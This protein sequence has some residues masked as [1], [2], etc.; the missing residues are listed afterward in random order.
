MFKDAPQDSKNKGRL[1]KGYATAFLGAYAYNALYSSLVGRDAAFDPI[2]ILEDLFRDLFGDD[3]EEPEEA[4]LNLADNVIEEVPFIGGLMGGG[5]VPISSAIPYEGDY[6]TF[7]TD[8]ANGELSA[9]EMLKPVYYLAMP[10]AGGQLKKTNE[11]LKM[12]DEDLPVAGSYTDSGN[13]RFPVEDDSIADWLQAALFGQYASKN[14]REYFDNGWAPLEEK[15]IDE[16]ASLDIPIADYRE[17]R[18]RL[19]KLNTL[20]EKLAYIH[21]LDL[22]I[23]K[24]NILANNLTDRKTPIDMEGWGKL[25]EFDYAVKYPEKAQFLVA[26]G[27]S[28]EEYKKLDDDTKDAY[29]WAYLNPEKHAVSK[30]VSN[31]IV[32][33]RKYTQELSEIKADKDSTGKTVSG[34][35]KKKVVQYINGLDAEYG[36]KLVLYKMEY[37]SDDT[38][39]GKII[40]Y[41]SGIEG[42]TFE[43]KAT[44]LKE[45][46]FTVTSDGKVTWN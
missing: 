18:K 24:K 28:V 37:P 26:N 46:G 29:D 20:G 13:L 22:P 17:I 3:E 7:I 9:K 36:A 38:Y 31:D 23:S 14:A 42:F 27:I 16:F 11:G 35:R 12:F 2:S 44:V 33:Y 5:R 45:L 30:T 41:V 6:K 32:T 15:Q 19:G 21:T 25:E 1:I 40:Q 8:I 43:Q 4:F 39:N 10:V 34:S